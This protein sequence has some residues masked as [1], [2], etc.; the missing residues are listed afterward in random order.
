MDFFVYRR[1]SCQRQVIAFARSERGRALRNSPVDCFSEGARRRDG[2][3]AERSYSPQ[4]Q[5][6]RNCI[7][8][9]SAQQN[10]ALSV[11]NNYLIFSFNLK[12]YF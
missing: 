2:S 4:I 8:Q 5:K 10:S 7:A 9:S 1:L 6:K 3:R 11:I 12:Y